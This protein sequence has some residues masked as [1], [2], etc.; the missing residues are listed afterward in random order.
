MT[1]RRETLVA[2]VPTPPKSRGVQTTSESTLPA[3]TTS[4]ALLARMRSVVSDLS[5]VELD[6]Q[7][8]QEMELLI[9]QTRQALFD[10]AT[11]RRAKS[12]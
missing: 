12:G 5:K 4:S 3:V 6:A 11:R 7:E 10:A 9:F 8:E 1:Y 2:V